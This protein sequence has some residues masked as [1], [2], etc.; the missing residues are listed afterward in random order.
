[1]IAQHLHTK[2]WKRVALHNAW[3]TTTMCDFCGTQI[4][5]AHILEHCIYPGR[6]KV[7]YCCAKTYRSDYSSDNSELDHAQMGRLSRFMDRNRWHRQR[8]TGRNIWLRVCYPNAERIPVTVWEYRRRYGVFIPD[9]LHS[10]TYA[11]QEDA[12]HAAFNVL[13]S[14]NDL[15]TIVE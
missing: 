4:E 10:R 7:G 15:W 8:K 2:E 11:L 14:L 1:M 12:M 6:I 13:D 3:D 9:A 5:W